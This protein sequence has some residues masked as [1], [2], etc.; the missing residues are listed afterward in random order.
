MLNRIIPL[1]IPLAWLNLIAEKKR[2]IVALAGIMFAVTMMLFQIGLNSALFTQVVSP[3]LKLDADI[4]VVSTQYEYFGISR[5]FARKRLVQAQAHPLV[6]MTT[7]LHLINL[8]L[9]NPETGRNRDIFIIGFDPTKPVFNDPVIRDWQDELK[10]QRSAIFDIQS[11]EEFG[12]FGTLLEEQPSV[13]TEVN[14]V[15]VN[16]VGLF[17]M[18]TTFAADGNII[19]SEATFLKVF[20]Q[21]S[22]GQIGVGLIQLKDGADP[23]VVAEAL[24]KQLKNDVTV[25]THQ[26]FV[27]L[28]Q[29]YWSER[30]PIGFVIT[31][32]MLVS[33]V[34]GAV[35]VY[36]ILY[37]DVTDH[38]EEYATLK[39]IGF[40]DGF[41]INLVLQESLILSLLGFVPGTLLT[42]WLYKLTRELAFMPT[43]LTPEKIGIVFGLTV[44]M[45]VCAGALAT[46]KL[47]HANPADIF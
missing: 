40:R 22:A 47:R 7:G 2:F 20:P 13:S 6:E 14:G 43:Y 35:I 39:S 11:R 16:V 34:V 28:E 27:E 8:P 37:T 33:L 5:T 32:S 46:R 24:S 26:E 31:A 36:Q 30:T 15:K 9:K 29:Q 12:A 44:F 42:A 21:A 4:V 17:E 45:C 19:V 1:G 23:K 38:L 10:V 41:F 3:H 18:G 25:M